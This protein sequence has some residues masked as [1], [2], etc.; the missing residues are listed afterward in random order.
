MAPGADA[1]VVACCVAAAWHPVR[2]T[3]MPD[4]LIALLIVP[5]WIA[6]MRFFGVYTSQ[7]LGGFGRLA[8]KIVSA[9]VLGLL[10]LIFCLG[11][12]G[13]WDRIPSALTVAGLSAG[14]LVAQ[15]AAAY[16]ALRMLRRRGFDAR[17]VLVIGSWE[18]TEEMNREF[19]R[20]PSW[21]LRVDCF[22]DGPIQS[23]AFYAFPGK[24]PL[25]DSLDGV[26]RSR[27]VDEVLIAV[28]PEEIANEHTTV[29]VCERYG[30]LGRV[31]LDR[32]PGFLDPE[33]S[34]D[35][36]GAVSFPVGGH[37]DRDAGLILKRVID[38][39]VSALASIVLT[40][41][42]VLI[43]V[44]VKLSSPGP[45]IFRQV[46]VGLR[47]RRFTMYKFRTMV[48]N[49][50]SQL[51]ALAA[52]TI[53]QGPIFKSPDD[54]RVTEVGRLL[55]RF[56]L[57]EL[58]QLLNVLKGEMS[59][60]GPRPLPI[61]ESEA[62]SGEFRRRFSMR[63][64]LTCLSQVRGRSDVEYTKWMKYDLQYIDGWSLWLDAKLIALT[65]PAVITGKG[66][67]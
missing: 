54:P 48:D 2:G 38:V 27:I 15:R 9:H 5:F 64:G 11:I 36:L 37:P 21:G 51:P 32:Q 14:V 29:Q 33:R 44:I 25:S 62:I 19:L 55:R 43:A 1:I 30:I 52:S 31:M 7:R 49:A 24:A 26:L 12:V 41:V 4:F 17:N 34:E 42:M 66:A 63:P 13:S 16:G 61:G 3:Q 10:G 6:L 23:R 18:K 45:V 8:G 50:E 47:G 65:I 22:G 67:Y 60:V 58:P 59:I 40:P 28:P 20:H 35:F 53:M 46:R 39:V 57:D 56:S